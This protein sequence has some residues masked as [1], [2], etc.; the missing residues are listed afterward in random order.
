[1]LCIIKAGPPISVS[2][3]QE[4]ES[5]VTMAAFAESLG[6]HDPKNTLR[7]E[8]RLKER[9]ILHLEGKEKGSQTVT[10]VNDAIN[11]LLG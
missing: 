5:L 4:T 3:V 6:V 9:I 11:F 8:L 10:E 1:M 7:D 2:A